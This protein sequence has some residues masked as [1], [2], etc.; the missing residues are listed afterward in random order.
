MAAVTGPIP[1][2]PGT[3]RKP[4][5]GMMCDDHPD[6]IA[7][8]R[9]QGETDSF[10][11]ELLDLCQEC[12]EQMRSVPVDTSGTCD[13]CKGTATDLR[14]RRDY[15]EGSTG[16]IYRVCGACVRKE[17]ARYAE[18]YEERHRYDCDED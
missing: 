3:L 11:C 5:D 6:R 16:R 1:T 15:E 14:D 7:V 9:V 12:L 17:N 13:L 4:P 18:E 8:A 10:G 2:L